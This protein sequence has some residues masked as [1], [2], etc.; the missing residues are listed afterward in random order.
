M[1]SKHAYVFSCVVCWG[2]KLVLDPFVP[3]LE[4]MQVG[5]LL[6]ACLSEVWV[7]LHEAEHVSA[8]LENPVSAAERGFGRRTC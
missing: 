1:W 5:T 7:G 4:Y 3:I 6:V 8:L 2:F